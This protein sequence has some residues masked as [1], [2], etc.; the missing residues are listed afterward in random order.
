MKKDISNHYFEEAKHIFPGGVNS[1]VRAFKAVGGNPIFI[2]NAKGSHLYDVDGNTYIDYVMSWGPMILGHAPE[3]VLEQVNQAIWQGT[4]FGAPSLREVS[5]GKLL[6]ERL[7][8]LEKMRMV[9]SGTEATMSAIRLAR[10]VTKRSKIIK[11]VGCY[12]GHSDSFLVQAGSGVAS[13]GIADSA[14]VIEQVA[15]E[16]IALPY[17]DVKALEETFLKQGDD[18]ACVIVEAVAGNMGLIPGDS[19]FIKAI[20]NLC[21]EH[22]ALFIVDEVM[23]GFRA[24]Y[25]GA[26]GLYDLDPD[27]VC[28]GKVIGGGFPVAAFGGKA[29]YMDQIAPLGPI[30]QAGTLSGNPIAMTAGYETLKELTADIFQSIAQKTSFLCQGIKEAADRHGIDLQVVCQGTMFGFFFAKDPVRH[31]EAAKASDHKL[32]AQL[33]GLL[34]EEGIYLAPSQYESNF[35]S[36]QHSQEDLEKTIAAFD[37]VFQMIKG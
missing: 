2:K 32:F 23:T 1:P 31:F 27:L 28:L 14:G 26:V 11:F 25:Q 18:I 12:H 34:L 15:S 37:R 4:S 22:Q 16:T 33:H 10:G 29:I 9:N 36:S 35:L 3:Q 20:E 5:L 7:P 8:Y 24:H 6:K 21:K 17:N 30:Y 19:S 13:F